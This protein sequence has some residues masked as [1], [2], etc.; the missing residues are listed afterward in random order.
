MEECAGCGEELAGESTEY[1]D[2][3]YCADCW[4]NNFSLCE[5]CDEVVAKDDLEYVARGSVSVAVCSICA[6]QYGSCTDCNESYH[7]NDL[8]VHNGERYCEDC[9]NNAHDDEDEDED[10]DEKEKI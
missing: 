10:E 5:D 9:H 6:K 4:E 3:V 2:D 7:E 8:I 1:N